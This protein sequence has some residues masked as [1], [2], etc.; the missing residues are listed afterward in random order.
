MKDY[1]V[2]FGIHAAIS[3]EIKLENTILKPS[4]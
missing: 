2:S 1:T 3:P 4:N